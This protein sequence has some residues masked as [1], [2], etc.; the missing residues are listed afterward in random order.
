[1][2]GKFSIAAA[3]LASRS[4]H[5]NH[6]ANAFSPRPHPSRGVPSSSAS[7]SSPLRR[8][9]SSSSSL[10]AAAADQYDMSTSLVADT[11]ESMG[12]DAERINLDE[13]IARL[14]TAGMAREEKA[15]RRRALDDLGVPDFMSFVSSDRDDQDVDDVGDDDDGIPVRDGKLI[16]SSPSILQLNIGLYCN[17]ACNHCHVESSPLR[18]SETM[19]SDVA[20]RCL[21]LLRDSPISVDTLDLTGGAPEL[22]AQFRLLV[23]MARAWSNESGRELTIIDRCNLTAL[24]EPGQEDL[25][26]FLRD[27]RVSVVASLPCYGEGNVD[28]QRGRG[29]FR[30]SIEA[31]SRLNDAGYGSPDRPDLTLDLVY[32][33][34][35]PFLPPSQSTLEVDYK[36]ELM[37][38]FGIRFNNL[39]TIT[40]MPIKRFADYLAREGKTG[41]YMELLVNNYNRKTV[42]GLMC[43]NTV[44]V[45]WDGM[46][47]DCDFNQ[48]LGMG[49]VGEGGRTTEKDGKIE[50]GGGGGAVEEES[51]RGG[52]RRR[53]L[54]V[55]DIGSLADL[56]EY[57]VRTDNHCFGCTAGSG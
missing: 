20:A 49:I 37:E 28:A 11:I 41:E 26:D 34:G 4:N 17:Q 47:Y 2:K 52:V 44:S 53:K 29:V 19:S 38:K 48:Q 24:I 40:N 57:S 3:I 27:N 8:W 6:A 21:A 33:P 1:M 55:F 22:N 15:R 31:L 35:G 50:E 9:A 13:R 43:L 23:S 5:Q 36:R 7:S 56:G 45:G 51:E 54:S 42:G 10:C 25:I 30:R 12:N 32:N 39:L 18:V 16:R 14:G 46:L